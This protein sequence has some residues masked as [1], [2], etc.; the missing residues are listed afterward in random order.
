MYFFAIITIYISMYYRNVWSWPIY[1]L[2]IKLYNFMHPVL[3]AKK[4][5]YNKKYLSHLIK[6]CFY[7]KNE[8]NVV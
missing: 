3:E 1:A 6:L 4:I 8:C 5:A 7:H 2:K